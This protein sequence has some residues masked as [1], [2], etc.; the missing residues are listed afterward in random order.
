VEMLEVH[1]G[2]LIIGDPAMTI[3]RAA[4]YVYD[5]ASEWRRATGLPF[6]FACLAIADDVEVG[7]QMIEL[8]TQAK[9]QGMAARAEIAAE[10]SRALNLPAASLLE[11]LIDNIN[12]DL[13]DENLAGL[14]RFYQLAAECNLIERN[15]ALKFI[16]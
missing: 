16:N 11:Y 15:T 14:A 4:Y 7:A 2:A 5:L 8:F 10:Y 3:D 13:D 6:V 1:D 9:A 12:Y